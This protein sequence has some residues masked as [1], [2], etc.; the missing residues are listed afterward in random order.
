MAHLAAVGF[1]TLMLRRLPRSGH[2]RRREA[3]TVVGSKSSLIS[4][5]AYLALPLTFVMGK[6]SELAAALPVRL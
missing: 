1:N 4:I 2:C 3:S 5:V 6:T